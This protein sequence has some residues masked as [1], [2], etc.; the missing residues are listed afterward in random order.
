MQGGDNFSGGAT[1]NIIT[2]GEGTVGKSS[3]IARLVENK[4][5]P[6]YSKTL[7]VDSK[8][9]TVNIDG[10][11]IKVRVWDTAGQENFRNRLPSTYFQ[12][13]DGIMFVYDLTSQITEEKLKNWV[14]DARNNIRI[15]FGRVVLGNKLDL[16]QATAP[17][18]QPTWESELESRVFF[19][20]ARTG[21]S[22]KE[23]FEYLVRDILQ[24]KAN[25]ASVLSRRSVSVLEHSKKKV[26]EGSKCC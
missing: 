20:S 16:L 2:V 18:A 26:N 19:T 14:N 8:K 22:V 13:A 21:E 25:L 5:D 17:Q 10:R 15:D 7:G 11:I 6:V 23:A 9:T 1:L 3:L 24:R 12:R 4:F